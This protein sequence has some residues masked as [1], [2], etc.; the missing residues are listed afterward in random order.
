MLT[1]ASM[2]NFLRTYAACKPG[3]PVTLP[4]RLSNSFG[5]VIQIQHQAQHVANVQ[6]QTSAAVDVVAASLNR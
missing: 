1:A 2:Q 5:L 3:G 4:L 6:L